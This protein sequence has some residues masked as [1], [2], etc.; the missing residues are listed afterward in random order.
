MLQSNI[1]LLVYTT[2]SEAHTGLYCWVV[3]QLC[4]QVRS[5]AGEGV[6]AAA[7]AW[8]SA[9]TFCAG[10]CCPSPPVIIGKIRNDCCWRILC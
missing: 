6:T 3:G 4:T 2:M 7:G 5:R 1:A 8:A 9:G 10:C